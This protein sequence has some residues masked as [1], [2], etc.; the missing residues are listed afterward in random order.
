MRL[1][2]IGF[3]MF[4]ALLLVSAGQEA[5]AQNAMADILIKQRSAAVEA[6]FKGDD[7]FEKERRFQAWIA[8]Y[9]P[10]NFTG[11]RIP[12]DYV[13]S[14]IGG[15][16]AK[17]KQF[18]KAVEYA[19]QIETPFWRG[20]GMA[21]IAYEL[22]RQGDTARASILIRKAIDSSLPFLNP[23]PNDNQA[24][25]AATGY[26]GYAT[27][28]AELMYKARKYEEALKFM[29]EADKYSK[30]KNAA[31]Y[32]TYANVLKR[33]GKNK[34]HT[35]QLETAVKEG[36]ANPQILAA[37]KVVYLENNKGEKE[38][39]IYLD[40]L[41]KAMKQKISTRVVK[42]IISEPAA[43]FSLKDLNGKL[44]SFADLKGKIVVLDFWATWCGPCVRSFPAMQR[45]VNL[46][47]TNPDVKFLFIDTYE[48]AANH[49]TLVR[50]FLEKNKYEFNVLFD[51]KADG[52]DNPSAAGAY[53]VSSIPAK[54]VID[55]RGKIR[56][57]LTGFTGGEDAAVA[58][59]VAMIDILAKGA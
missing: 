28:Y 49:E 37:L 35:L 23:A 59:L 34:E 30:M 45:A 5:E 57:K 7:P 4:V 36:F 3:L 11:I 44:V 42:E 13:R 8:K 33:T 41:N 26:P 40:G 56:F 18:D 58:E 10:E 21:G 54:F 39:L 24:Q 25:F 22:L 51:A 31:F 12:Y 19:N 17:A 29:Q 50:S 38:Y 27:T 16:F 15:G 14:G 48:T 6:I 53:H 2:N 47:K 9:P 52:A 1:K 43:A 55:G 46:Y 32:L 20:E